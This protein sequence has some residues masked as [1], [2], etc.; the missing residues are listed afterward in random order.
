MSS[1]GF[2]NDTSAA[3]VA[4]LAPNSYRVSSRTGYFFVIA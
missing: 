3:T 4:A 2:E 1:S